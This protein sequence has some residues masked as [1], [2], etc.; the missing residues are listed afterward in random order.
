MLPSLPDWRTSSCG[1]S[2]HTCVRLSARIKT[3]REAASAWLDFHASSSDMPARPCRQQLQCEP[4]DGSINELRAIVLVDDFVKV[5]AVTVA[6][7]DG[8][9]V[10][11]ESRAGLFVRCE[12]HVQL[13]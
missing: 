9:L 8:A 6:R 5:I 4:S 3:C 1:R 13:S 11:G 12:G 2:C 10:L 7:Q